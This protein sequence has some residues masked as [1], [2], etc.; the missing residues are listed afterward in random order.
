MPRQF[1]PLLV[2]GALFLLMMAMRA[3]AG[4]ANPSAQLGAVAQH[5]GIPI[6]LGSPSYNLVLG[7]TPNI[8][9]SMFGVT[10]HDVR[11]RAAGMHGAQQLSF[12]VHD[13]LTRVRL[14]RLTLHEADAFQ[15]A[16]TLEPVN[17]PFPFEITVR[18]QYGLQSTPSRGYPVVA[19]GQA[20]AGTGRS[21][22]R[23]PLPRSTLARMR[24]RLRRSYPRAT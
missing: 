23:T 9:F 10:K 1:Y 6:V 7:P 20:A 24:T 8:L 21:Q 22:A 16:L 14:R 3:I 13:K 4:S 15:A 2:I 18:G 11:V 12:D 17:L 19:Q 5:L